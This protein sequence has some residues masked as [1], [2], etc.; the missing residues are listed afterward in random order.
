MSESATHI[1]IPDEE[2]RKQF[3]STEASVQ[4]IQDP[5]N[6]GA[7][8]SFAVDD[9]KLSR[10]IQLVTTLCPNR[11]FCFLNEQLLFKQAKRFQS[12]FLPEDPRQAIAYAV[13][14]NPRARILEIFNQA[15]LSFVDISS[16]GEIEKVSQHW[17]SASQL[18]T[19]PA[20][21]PE[22]IELALDQGIRYFTVEDQE[23]IQNILSASRAAGIP[24]E[25]IEIAIRIEHKGQDADINLSEKF[26]E[27]IKRSIELIKFVR[28]QSSAQLGLATNTGSQ[29]RNPDSY[30]KAFETLIDLGQTAGGISSL[31]LGGGFPINYG[32]EDKFKLEDYMTAIN[33]TVRKHANKA[34]RGPNPKIIIEPGRALVAEAIDLIIPIRKRKQKG[35]QEILLIDDGIYTCFIDALVHGWTYYFEGLGR[36]GRKLNDENYEFRIMGRTCD[37]GDKLLQTAYLPSNLRSSDY[38][39][40]RNSGA[41]TDST[42]TINFNGFQKPA[43][44]SYNCIKNPS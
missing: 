23:E 38:L 18:Y 12:L 41:Y 22:E 43:Y 19:Y 37:N 26:G 5:S 15:G 3:K 1:Y 25:Q 35:G 27:D 42:S 10:V 2:S 7:E 9:P 33:S 31:N 29:N 16:L 4:I 6:V 14:A 34:L 8:I 20:R 44:V 28:D 30:A 40:V 24:D 13:K 21:F 17:P 32:P 36:E 39:K 11:A